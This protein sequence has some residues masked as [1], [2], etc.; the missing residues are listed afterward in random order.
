MLI[1]LVLRSN[2]FTIWIFLFVL[3]IF[4][5]PISN[6][7]TRAHTHTTRNYGQVEILLVVIQVVYN[8]KQ[9]KS[10]S[11]CLPLFYTPMKESLRLN[12][13]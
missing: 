9:S 6:T 8:K 13:G 3:Y 4:I 12:H 10:F 1:I 7:H 2:Y 5:F 11:H